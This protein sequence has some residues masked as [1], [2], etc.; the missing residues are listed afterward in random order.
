M[1]QAQSGLPGPGSGGQEADAKMKVAADAQAAG[2]VGGHASAQI[3][4]DLT[5][6]V[7]VGAQDRVRPFSPRRLQRDA[8]TIEDHVTGP[9]GGALEANPRRRTAQLE[10]GRVITSEQLPQDLGDGLRHRHTGPLRCRG[11]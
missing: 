8:A 2:L 6:P 4:G 5:P 3:I 10:D 11:S 1:T 9:L 7:G